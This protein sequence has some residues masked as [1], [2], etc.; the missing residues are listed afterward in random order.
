MRCGACCEDSR[1][2]RAEE[3]VDFAVPE[4]ARY[5]IWAQA[6]SYVRAR[7][8]SAIGITAPLTISKSKQQYRDQHAGD[9]Y[10]WT[11]ASALSPSVWS[12]IRTLSP[13]LYPPTGRRTTARLPPS[14]RRKGGSA[15]T[16]VDLGT[17][18][19]ARDVTNGTK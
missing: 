10:Q 12:R 2:R 4:C 13:N 1:F 18:W 19:D 11:H 8:P 16:H 9:W 17:K 7:C 6:L 3:V 5:E 14:A 15:C